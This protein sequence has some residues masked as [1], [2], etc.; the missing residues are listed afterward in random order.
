MEIFAFVTTTGS[1][2]LLLDLSPSL[3]SREVGPE[4]DDI[5][6]EGG[7]KHLNFMDS[8]LAHEEMA[9]APSCG[10]VVVEAASPPAS[11]CQKKTHPLPKTCSVFR[12]SFYVL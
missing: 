5:P 11:P 1:S 7:A 3:P 12:V 6:P 4:E 9:E 10:G 2:K 8:I